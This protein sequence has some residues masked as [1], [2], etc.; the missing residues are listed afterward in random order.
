MFECLRR[1]TLPI[2]LSII[3]LVLIAPWPA[4]ANR[5]A[6]LGPTVVAS[7]DLQRVMDSLA[8]RADLEAALTAQSQGII[9]E[10]NRRQAEI[11]GLSKELEDMVEGPERTSLQEELDL[12][13][14]QEMAWMRFIQQEIDI[15][16]SLMLENLY[17]S[18]Q[19]NVTELAEIEGI[20]LVVINDSGDQF[21]VAGGM[22]IPRQEQIREQIA[23]RRVLYRSASIDISDDLIIRMNNEYAAS[24]G[25]R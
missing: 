11:E 9:A 21:A 7:I 24:A 13:L 23:M 17:R 22:K 19:K 10:R 25:S 1:S 8:E 20:D 12:K 2:L 14:L 6:S 4:Q 18:M 5:M 16:K 15:E 3:V